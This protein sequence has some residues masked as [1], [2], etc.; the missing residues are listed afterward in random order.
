MAVEMMAAHAA[1]KRPEPPF[2][3]IVRENV[4]SLALFES[5]GF[6]REEAVRWCRFQV[7]KVAAA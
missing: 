4:G 1:G 6:G 3:Y 2:C 7:G 5:I